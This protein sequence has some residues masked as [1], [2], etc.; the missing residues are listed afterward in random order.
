[1]QSNFRV[2]AIITY[3]YDAGDGTQGI[4]WVSGSNWEP[5][6]WRVSLRR[7]VCCCTAER[8]G[9]GDAHNCR[10]PDER[11][12]HVHHPWGSL[13]RFPP[14]HEQSRYAYTY[15]GSRGRDKIDHAR[16]NISPPQP[17]HGDFVRQRSSARGCSSKELS[18]SSLPFRI[19]TQ[20]R[21]CAASTT[22]YESH[23]KDVGEGLHPSNTPPRFTFL[24]GPWKSRGNGKH[25]VRQHSG[26]SLVSHALNAAKKSA[27]A[28]AVFAV[29]VDHL[30]SYTRR[31]LLRVRSYPSSARGLRI[32]RSCRRGIVPYGHLSATA[33]NLSRMRPTWLKFLAETDYTENTLILMLYLACAYAA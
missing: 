24:T 26:C 11:Y 2:Y 30:E 28:H 5:C 23:G 12:G 19:G 15:D 16:G 29:Q 31:L 22:H 20:A 21:P 32:L 25:S 27:S 7:A 4:G 8:V 14:E 1:M 9:R 3:E 6:Y 33:E 10:V 13:P 17:V 18:P